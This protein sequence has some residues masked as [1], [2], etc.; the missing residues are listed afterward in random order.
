[1]ST[2]EM[3]GTQGTTQPVPDAD[4]K[5]E[6]PRFASSSFTTQADQGTLPN[7][8]VAPQP[9][10]IHRVIAMGTPDHLTTETA[11]ISRRVRHSDQTVNK[12]KLNEHFNLRGQLTL[13]ISM[14]CLGAAKRTH[15]MPV[16]LSHSTVVTCDHALSARA[17]LGC[18]HHM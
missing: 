6:H 17:R 4:Q 3:L 16:G 15:E 7:V 8:V 2:Q 1:M 9:S 5:G 13:W 14:H 10:T 12:T 11:A 18:A